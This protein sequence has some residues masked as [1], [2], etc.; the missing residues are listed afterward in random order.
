MTLPPLAI[1]IHENVVTL[2]FTARNMHARYVVDR[3]GNEHERGP[4]QYSEFSAS[5]HVFGDTDE[6]FHVNVGKAMA[7]L[8]R[9]A[10]R[11]M[12]ILETGNIDYVAVDE[13]FASQTAPGN[14]PDRLCDEPRRVG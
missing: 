5:I 9:V 2:R 3:E 13:Q 6:E 1:T 7:R 10:R 4:S 8:Y 14:R 11:T 12:E